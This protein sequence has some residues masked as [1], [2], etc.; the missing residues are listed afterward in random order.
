M[1]W[2]LV[3]VAGLAMAAGSAMA[4]DAIQGLWTHP[5]FETQRTQVAKEMTAGGKYGEM[6]AADQKK[7]NETLERME[8]RWQSAA[9]GQLTDAEQVAMVNDQEVVVTALDKGAAD[10]RVVCERVAQI[11][12]NLP[13]NVCKTVAQRKR[14]MI[15]AQNAAQ[16]G[17]VETN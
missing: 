15:E 12:S 5:Q 16:A 11:G 3:W 8:Q 10:S 7:V 2:G 14:E 4:G 17:K 9:N 6:S 1:K 13:K